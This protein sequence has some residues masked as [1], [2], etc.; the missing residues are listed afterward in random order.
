MPELALALIVS[1]ADFFEISVDALLGY[2]W[3]TGAMGDALKQIKNYT[4]SKDYK[5]GVPFVEKALLKF[6][7]SFE[8]VYKSAIFYLVS[9]EEEKVRRSIEL[10]RKAEGL[11]DQNTDER[12]CI[13]SIGNDVAMAYQVLGDKEKDADIMKKN[14]VDGI[15]SCELGLLYAKE[16]HEPEEAMN[17]LSDC[18][19]VRKW[20][21]HHIESIDGRQ[22]RFHRQD[23]I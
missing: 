21:V 8:I 14:N 12:I 17:Y 16:F 4:Q 11:I 19:R 3:Q 20:K 5:R 15:N 2:R 9:F 1:I 23:S 22:E 7:N 10:F 6:P 18:R 13:H